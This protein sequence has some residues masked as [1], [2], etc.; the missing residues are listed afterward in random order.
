MREP[1]EDG[2]ATTISD[3][4]LGCTSTIGG[5][6]VGGMNPLYRCAFDRARCFEYSPKVPEPPPGEQPEPPYCDT[7]TVSWPIFFS[8]AEQGSIERDMHRGDALHRWVGSSKECLAGWRNFGCAYNYDM[9]NQATGKVQTGPASP[10]CHGRCMDMVA[11]CGNE[12]IA[13]M[14]KTTKRFIGVCVCVCCCTVFNP[15]SLH[16]VP[17]PC[18]LLH[19]DGC[20][21]GW[22]CDGHG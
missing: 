16:L 12:T 7:A 2:E 9:C 5:V 20:W 1:D 15:T 19:V 10:D 6:D 11:A 13:A 14:L 17:T 4:G 18:V 3:D 8:P 21:E 22:V